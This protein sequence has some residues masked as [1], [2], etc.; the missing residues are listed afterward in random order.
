MSESLRF[1]VMHFMPYVHLP[2]SHKDF[3]STW[4]DLP[5]S[6]DDP[7]KGH[8]LYPRNFEQTVSKNLVPDAEVRIFEGAGHLV[9]LEAPE[10]VSVI[11]TFLGRGIGENAGQ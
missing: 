11:G 9:H 1:D 5:N 8:E 2:S 3:K 6:S 4:V 10:A 7:V